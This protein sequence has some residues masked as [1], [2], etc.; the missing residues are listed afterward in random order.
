VLSREEVEPDV[1]GRI[2]LRD[3]ETGEAFSLR[4][5]DAAAARYRRA[6]RDF[7]EDWSRFCSAHDLR[8]LAT[9]TDVPF[10]DFV[11]RYLRRGGLVR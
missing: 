9:T 2:R 3:A 8:F 7:G 5:T 10:E 1:R 4:L 11:M 6:L